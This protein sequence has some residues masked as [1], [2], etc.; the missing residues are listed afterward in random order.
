MVDISSRQNVGNVNHRKKRIAFFFGTKARHLAL[1]CECLLAFGTF[2]M[3]LAVAYKEPFLY[4]VGNAS[5][6]QRVCRV[7]VAAGISNNAVFVTTVTAKV[8]YSSSGH[9][10]FFSLPVRIEWLMGCCDL[11][12]GALQRGAL[13]G[14]TTG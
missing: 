1:D 13:A 5:L 6:A 3:V 4:I 11:Q 10:P 12:R 9:A 8:G 7:L 14:W 2:D